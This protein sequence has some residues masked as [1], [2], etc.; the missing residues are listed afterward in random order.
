MRRWFLHPWHGKIW[1]NYLVCGWRHSSRK[2]IAILLVIKNAIDLMKWT[3]WIKIFL[4]VRTQTDRSRISHCGLDCTTWTAF[5]NWNLRQMF[6]ARRGQD[7]HRDRYK[8]PVTVAHAPSN[9]PISKTF[10]AP[11]QNFRLSHNWWF[12]RIPK[13]HACLENV[14]LL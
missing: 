13:F 8:P 14:M 7:F 3:T 5:Q 1:A 6:S 12:R 9:L 2:L 4:F 10:L 11:L